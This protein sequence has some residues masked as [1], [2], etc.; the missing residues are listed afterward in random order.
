MNSLRPASSQ[1]EP[2]RLGVSGPFTG[3]S[4]PMGESMR[5]GIRLAARE[6]NALGGA[7]GRPIELI[8]RDDRANPALGRKIA[9]EFVRTD[10][11]AA[12]GVVNT[13]V[14]MASIDVYQQ[15]RVPLM[16]A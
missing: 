15:A 1:A 2:I 11:S 3:G 10:V 13:G 14:G 9:E 4:A 6:L 8:E 7:L 16:V 12:I 5:N